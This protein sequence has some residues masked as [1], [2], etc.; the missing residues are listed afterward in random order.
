MVIGI[1]QNVGATSKA[2]ALAIKFGLKVLQ[3]VESLEV[4]PTYPTGKNGQDA[5]KT[6]TQNNINKG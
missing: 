6:N 5:E 2:E 4:D 3:D 1:L